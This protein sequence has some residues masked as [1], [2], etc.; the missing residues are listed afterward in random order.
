[1][2]TG[3][4]GKHT[5]GIVGAG[6]I[7]EAI[8]AGLLGSKRIAPGQILVINRSNRDR[9]E[10]LEWR[11]GVRVAPSHAVLAERSTALL[12]A[13][14]PQDMAKVTDDL[15]GHTTAAHRILSVAAGVSIPFLERA[16]PGSPVVRAM[17]NTP[18]AIGE[19]ATAYALGTRAGPDDAALAREIFGTVGHVV[20]VP[21]E[22]L[23][24][25]TGLSG[26]GPAY[27]FLLVEIL[28]EGGVRAGLPPE[29]ARD[30][31]VQTVRGA[32]HLLQ[33][34]GADPAELRRRVTSPNGTTAAAMQV[35]ADRQ[36]REAWVEAVLRATA[37]ARELREEG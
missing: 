12:L 9:L 14:K 31:V 15:A 6:S 19:A 34:S 7:A 2:N 27:V 29:I 20:E 33:A 13:A 25:V 24:A 18:C 17:P 8:I 23:D 22:H 5:I 1:M 36:V 26:T 3:V 10:A 32:A 30:L 21:E 11:Y 35:L 4:L 16:F 28:M 37:R